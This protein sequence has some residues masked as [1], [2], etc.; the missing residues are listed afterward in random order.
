MTIKEVTENTDRRMFAEHKKRYKKEHK[1]LKEMT[2]AFNKEAKETNCDY[3]ISITVHK[4]GQAFA[5]LD[6][7]KKCKFLWSRWIE[8]ERINQI[9][10]SDSSVFSFCDH[11]IK[12]KEFRDIEKVI[13]KIPFEF[14]V[15][16]KDGKVPDK[17]Q[18]LKSL[19]E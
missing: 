5:Q 15:E 18:I 14:E 2:D 6:R 19:E 3:R 7:I 8:A 11:G 1:K 4:D 13:N 16:I 9:Y 12:I 17:Y 10:V